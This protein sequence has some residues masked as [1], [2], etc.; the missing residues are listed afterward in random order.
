MRVADGG[1]SHR[2][3]RRGATCEG[4]LLIRIRDR[5]IPQRARLTTSPDRSF[6]KWSA[7]TT[8][9][10]EWLLTEDTWRS[11]RSATGQKGHCSRDSRQPPQPGHANYRD[12]EE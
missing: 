4:W 5:P 3:W 10:D 1:K 9:A 8:L 2:K 7:P 11:R 12:L 6:S